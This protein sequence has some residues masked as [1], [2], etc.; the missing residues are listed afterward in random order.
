MS[1]AY[2]LLALGEATPGMVLSHELIDLNGQVLLAKGAVL[3]EAII[4]S[5]ARHGIEAVP[6]GRAQEAAEA[7]DP[8]AVLARLDHV[9]R[10]ND[11]D[12]SGDWATGLLRR[13]V[14]DYRL[15]REL[16]P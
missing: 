6:V 1:D 3:T 10:N 14:E 11:R 8:Q 12:D 4:A 7:P 13:Y 5:L 15:G 16:A 9:F 2:Q